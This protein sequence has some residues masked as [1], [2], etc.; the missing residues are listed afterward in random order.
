MFGQFVRGCGCCL[1]LCL[2]VMK[3]ILA[4][5]VVRAY[6]HNCIVKLCHIVNKKQT[7]NK[8]DRCYTHTERER[9]RK[10]ERK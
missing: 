7:N 4:G 9:E 1:P 10:R 8:K 5:V 6:A 2:S 3:C